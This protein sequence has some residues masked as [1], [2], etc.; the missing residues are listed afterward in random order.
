MLSCIAVGVRFIARCDSISALP[1]TLTESGY[2]NRTAHFEDYLSADRCL[3]CGYGIRDTEKAFG[4]AYPALAHAN[5]LP[6][7]IDATAAADN[8]V[9]SLP[10]ADYPPPPSFRRSIWSA[11]FHDASNSGANS[12]SAAAANGSSNH[13]KSQPNGK[14]S[15]SKLA[16]LPP[17]STI[18]DFLASVLV[19][20]DGASEP[21]ANGNT[22]GSGSGGGSGGGG[23]DDS[24]D[25]ITAA[26]N[27]TAAV[28]SDGDQSGDSDEDSDEAQDRRDARDS[29]S[30][31]SEVD[32]HERRER[33]KD[34]AFV[35]D[36]DDFLDEE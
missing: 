10:A 1:Q 22:G 3:C 15:H 36:G 8:S 31:D 34:R 32:E 17:R 19:P 30:D 23:G 25:E 7:P 16:P 26:A 21:H 9:E 33:E 6:P 28:A 29:Y 24:G 2:V 18:N 27:R 13:S 4:K 35:V 12:T 11:Y 20:K 14:S 5:A